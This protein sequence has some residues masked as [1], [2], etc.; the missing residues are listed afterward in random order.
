MMLKSCEQ[1]ALMA[2]NNDNNK[3]AYKA[4]MQE[5]AEQLAVLSDEAKDLVARLP[6]AQKATA[7]A[8]LAQFSSGAQTALDLDSVFYMSALLYPDNHK[9]G[10]PD[11]M[12]TL[13]QSLES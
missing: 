1:L 6:E 2:L 4:L 11:N 10:E 7:A 5:R 9:A 13:I 8:S 12:E 3:E